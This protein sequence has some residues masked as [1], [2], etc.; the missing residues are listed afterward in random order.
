MNA[1]NSKTIS[2]TNKLRYGI[3][4]LLLATIT[5]LQ[6]YIKEK[7]V[8]DLRRIPIYELIK[9]YNSV[10]TIKKNIPQEKYNAFMTSLEHIDIPVEKY[11]ELV[12]SVTKNK[13]QIFTLLKK[14]NVDLEKLLQKSVMSIVKKN[15]QYLSKNELEFLEDFKKI[16]SISKNQLKLMEDLD[17]NARKFDLI[18]KNG[19]YV[20]GSFWI[21]L[22]ISALTLFV[23][24]KTA[25][26]RGKEDRSN[27]GV[28]A[29]ISAGISLISLTSYYGC[30]GCLV[31]Q[32]KREDDLIYES[33]TE[34]KIQ[35]ELEKKYQDAQPVIDMTPTIVLPAVM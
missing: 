12:N 16:L 11:D 21:L 7:N 15:P 31:T 30:K 3:T 28:A 33:T 19:G 13:N 23:S 9:N 17:G 22:C 20:L 10:A 32:E 4:T 2:V 27:L 6:C 14:H 1:Y 35:K 8:L 24:D 25:K 26:S 5:N 34:Y 18:F 29:F